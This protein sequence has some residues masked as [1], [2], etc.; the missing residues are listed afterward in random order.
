VYVFTYRGKPVARL[1]NSAWMRAWRIAG[2]PVEKGILKGVHNLRHNF[3]RRLRGAGVPVETRKAL[4]GHANGDITTHYSAA[5]IQELLEAAEMIVNRGIAQTPTLATVK[6]S[7]ETVGR[8]SE[9]KKG[10]TLEIR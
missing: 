4:L 7:K 2:L 10:L 6:R 1:N 9:N 3:G 8:V 5:E